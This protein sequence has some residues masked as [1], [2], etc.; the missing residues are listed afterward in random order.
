MRAEDVDGVDGVR[1]A[2]EDKVGGVQTYPQVGQVYVFDGARH[3]GWR[4]LSC[5][6]E[7]ALAVRGAVLGNVLNGEDGFVVERVARVFRDEAAVGLD[8]RDAEELGE[9]GGLLEAV[10]AGGAAVARDDDQS[11]MGRLR[12]PRR[13]GRDLRLLLWWR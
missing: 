8:L 4:F 9:V 6:H 1:F 2:V 5:L 13:G 7:E 11:W 3:G 12:S 10:D